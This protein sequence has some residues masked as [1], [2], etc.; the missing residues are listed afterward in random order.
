MVPGAK[1][2]G[3]AGL[4]GERLK[5]RVSE[6]AEAGKATQAVGQL[7]AEYLTVGVELV[8]GMTSRRKLFLAS[9]IDADTARS[10]LGV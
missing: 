5:V 6:P 2:P 7:L 8:K 3:I 10:K 9:G 4:H 1:K